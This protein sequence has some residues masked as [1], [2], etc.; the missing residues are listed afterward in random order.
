MRTLD[1]CARL[2]LLPVMTLMMLPAVELTLPFA[3][4]VPHAHAGS[5]TVGGRR[6][7]CRRARV[8]I[9]RALPGVGAAE[10]GTIFLNPDLLRRYPAV[11]RR[12]IFLH[13]CGH[14]YVGASETGADCW[15][16]RAA[17]R[18]GWL[19]ERGVRTVCRSFIN[20]PGFGRHPPGPAR[21][22][23]MI[24]CFRRAPA[25]RGRS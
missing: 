5:A 23:A 18:Q 8:L 1:Y 22:R 10:R 12:I 13:E 3:V 15:A 14:Q 16:V 21:C 4:S 2:F 6:L 19:T 17:K 20:Q 25:R 24:S 7:S 9:T 11:T